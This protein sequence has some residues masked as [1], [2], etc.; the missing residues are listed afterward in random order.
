VLAAHSTT[1]V[2]G[3]DYAWLWDV[4][5]EQLVPRLASLIVSGN[6]ADEVVLRFKYA[7]VSSA[8]MRVLPGRPAALDAAL[9][10]IPPGEPLY[11]FAGYTPMR[12]LRTV[13]QRRGWVQPSWKE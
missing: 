5:L 6:R 3:Q 2:D 7:G 11:I 4:D 9:A 10:G 1:P 12:E 8:A 13:M